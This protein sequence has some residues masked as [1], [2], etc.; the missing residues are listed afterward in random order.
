M[1]DLR[2]FIERCDPT[3]IGLYLVEYDRL[4]EQKEAADRALRAI[5]FNAS[6]WHAGESGYRRALNVIQAWAAH[7]ESIPEGI[8]GEE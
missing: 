6:S 8:G 7:P 3:S 1:S 4:V 5:H 2:S